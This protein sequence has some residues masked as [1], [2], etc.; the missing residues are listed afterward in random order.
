MI[1]LLTDF[2]NDPFP[3]VMKGMIRRFH[4]TVEVVDLTHHIPF[5]DVMAASF[6]LHVHHRVFPD[7]SIFVAVVDPGVGSERKALAVESGRYLFLAPDNGLLTPFLDDAKQIIDLQSVGLPLSKTFHGRDLF[8]PAAAKLAGD[9]LLTDLG[10]AL[11][12]QAVRLPW[13]EVQREKGKLVGE[14]I[15]T[16]HYGNLITNIV[17][18]LTI[19]AVSV[20]GE[21]VRMGQHYSTVPEGEAIALMGSSGYLEVAVR[22]GSAEERFGG[23]GTQ[24]VVVF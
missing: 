18:P 8:A 24:V 21:T 1:V 11:A 15:A 6:W 19:Q 20:G 4:P 2:G 12:G 5:G 14:V 3:G 23:R 9:M 17:A 16:D 7:G 13:P 10:P 22:L